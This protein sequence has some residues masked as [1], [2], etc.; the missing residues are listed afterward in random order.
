MVLCACASFLDDND[1]KMVLVRV[2]GRVVELEQCGIPPTKLFALYDQIHTTGNYAGALQSS[3][4]LI[5]QATVVTILCLWRIQ[6]RFPCG[7]SD[8]RFLPWR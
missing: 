7:S 3:Q 8:D 2:T 6:S 5:Y 4:C 1:K